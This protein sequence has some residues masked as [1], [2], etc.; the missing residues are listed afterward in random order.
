MAEHAIPQNI[1]EYEFKLF[2]G[3]TWK[4]FIYAAIGGVLSFIIFQM[5]LGKKIPAI[6]GWPL[7]FI[8]AAATLALTFFT[9]EKRSLDQWI[10]DYLRAMSIPLIRVWKKD[11]KPVKY[12]PKKRYKPET[13][14]DYLSVYFKKE[15]EI[16]SAHK[17]VEHTL[18]QIQQPKVIN[19]N[20]SNH[21]QFSTL[22]IKIPEIP[23]TVAF[24]LV[25]NNQPVEGVVAR[26]YDINNKEL[27]ALKST[28]HG[29]IYFN[30]P[31]NNGTYR[32]V[33]NHPK[34]RFP[35]VHITF[36]NNTYPLF[37]IVGEQNG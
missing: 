19:I 14:P 17:K 37:N 31:L 1:M 8:T 2:A 27:R 29:I 23:N 30:K 33:F 16:S 21:T 7:L 32:I 13:F 12:D 22:N 10:Q 9:Y 28:P 5:T 6:F 11:Y 18:K 35:E 26:L 36:Q 20:P 3:L 24:R 15:V 34:I 4:Q 25:S